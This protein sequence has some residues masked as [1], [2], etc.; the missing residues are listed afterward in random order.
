MQDA[1]LIVD[2]DPAVLDTLSAVLEEA[3]HTVYRCA[4]PRL[5]LERVWDLRPRLVITDLMMPRLGGLDVLRRVKGIDPGIQVIVITGYGSTGE[6]V[7]AM[8]EGAFDFI[9]KPF[10]VAV[11]E[12]TVRRALD[13]SSEA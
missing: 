12:A 7:E 2:D 11:I 5:A 10:N 9:G 1:I 8:R 3:G 6:A 13:A 4:E